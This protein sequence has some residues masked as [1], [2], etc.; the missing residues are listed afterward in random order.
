M[1]DQS[2]RGI[3]DMF[4]Q[5]Y[6][7]WE[8]SA[9]EQFEKVARSQSFLTAL[10]QN[11]DQTLNISQRVKDITQSTLNMMNLPTQQDVAGLAKQLRTLRNSMDE[12]N[13]KLDKINRS[14]AKSSA[15]KS[16]AKA[17]KAGKGA[18]AKS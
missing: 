12:M 17:K 14:T 13:T 5:V 11:L 8:K 15:T 1:S 9:T 10:A 16:K 6:E 3:R 18:K 2:D 4:K 7:M